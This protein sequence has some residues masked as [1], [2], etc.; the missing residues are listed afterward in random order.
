M[1]TIRGMQYAEVVAV[2]NSLIPEM[3]STGDPQAVL[4]KYARENNLTPAVLE[5]MGQA[6]NQ[7]SAIQTMMGPDRGADA[8]LLDLE[9]MAG[10]YA[11]WKPT[12]DQE[13]EASIPATTKIPWFATAMLREKQA[14]DY[15]P[16]PVAPVA[17]TPEPEKQ[18]G[19]SDES[20]EKWESMADNFL[21]LLEKAAGEFSRRLF[22]DGDVEGDE[23]NSFILSDAAESDAIRRHGDMA[24]KAFDWYQAWSARRWGATV[25]R[26]SDQQIGMFKLAN[27]WSGKL[28]EASLMVQCFE[29][30]AQCLEKVAGGDIDVRRGKVRSG[31]VG[32][33]NDPSVRS[34]D[35]ENPEPQ[36]SV[37]DTEI[38]DPPRGQP[39][40]SPGG[41][42]S[43]DPPVRIYH[44][45]DEE[46]PKEKPKATE[47]APAPDFSPAVKDIMG[48]L[49]APSHR[50]GGQ[51][52][53][54]LDEPRKNKA[55]MGV[56]TSVQTAMQHHNLQ[57]LLLTDPV[58]SK[59]DPEEVASI[60]ES[61]R[62]GSD[63][64]AS[65]INLLR[66]QLR[67]ALQYGGVP[68]DAYKQLL[69]I[70]E[71]RDTHNRASRDADKLRYG[72]GPTT[73]APSESR[74]ARS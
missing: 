68:P 17:Q 22:A 7:G 59:A 74:K 8:P 45:W 1:G 43:E 9:S 30:M 49:T 6:Y 36:P 20:F 27:D 63:D 2:V 16:E 51:M 70:T 69:S 41:V 52:S 3:V 57:K 58:I 54:W 12:V 64:V 24:K 50:L 40:V 26:A 56:D 37:E 62:R 15:A 19:M 33:R 67:E 29:S 10:K 5:R 4:L 65:D 18:A 28:E 73:G 60:Y 53:K 44:R 39:S 61:I 21:D 34:V 35:I 14:A 38:N 31:G 66:F 13:K 32:R 46:Q 47:P 55:Q 25:K 23:H 42:E 11:D 71:L 48:M 72:G